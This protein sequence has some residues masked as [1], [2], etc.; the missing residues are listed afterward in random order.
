MHQLLPLVEEYQVNG[1]K[2][3]C[4]EYLLTKPGSMELLITAQSYGLEMLL[5]KNIEYAR[6]KSYSELQRDP[7]FSSLEPENLLRVLEL[8]VL[9]LEELVEHNKKVSSERDARLYGVITEL[10]SGYGNF[11]TDCK[12]RKVN[13]TCFNCLKMF[14]EKVKG[15]CEEAKHLR[16]PYT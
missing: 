10:A 7:Y 1:I 9:D 11:C 16:T 3:K 13:E 4:E 5:S 6:K 14:R 8:R 2:K 15:K 12:T